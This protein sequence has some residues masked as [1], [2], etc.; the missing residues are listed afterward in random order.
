[1]DADGDAIAL[2][3]TNKWRKAA[4]AN[5]VKVQEDAVRAGVVQVMALLVPLPKRCCCPQGFPRGL[6]CTT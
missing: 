2:R 3:D 1:M 6:L 4:V 5:A